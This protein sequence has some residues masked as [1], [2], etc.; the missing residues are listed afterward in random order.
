MAQKGPIVIW[1]NGIKVVRYRSLVS[2]LAAFFQ[3]R[4]S[5]VPTRGRWEWRDRKGAKIFSSMKEVL[6]LCR[7]R[8]CWGW[9][10]NHKTLHLWIGR[11][12]KFSEAIGLIAH[13]LGHREKPWGHGAQEEQKAAR[14]EAVAQDAVDLLAV[15]QKRPRTKRKSV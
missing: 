11:K 4:P 1:M 10:A 14:Y 15:L 3:C 2:C 13:E 7:D 12:A 5:E 8:G 6:R 9:T